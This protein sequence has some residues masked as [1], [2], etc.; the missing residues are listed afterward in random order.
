MT[1]TALCVL[2]LIAVFAILLN[3]WDSIAYAQ[4]EQDYGGYS[5]LDEYCKAEYG[6]EYFFDPVNYS[7][8]ISTDAPDDLLFWD[9][10]RPLNW[11]DFQG[12]PNT[13]SDDYVGD[14]SDTAGAH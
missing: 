7:C 8:G 10:N 2:C 1:K 4:N 5:S 14:R 12:E 6:E 9:E 13:Y 11:S 3:N